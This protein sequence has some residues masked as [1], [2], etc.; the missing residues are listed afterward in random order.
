MVDGLSCNG[1]FGAGGQG[2][3]GATSAPGRS[4]RAGVAAVL[5]VVLALACLDL[6]AELVFRSAQPADGSQRW[7]ELKRYSD[8]APTA[9]PR[10]AADDA[11]ASTD[12]VQITVSGFITEEDVADAKV[13]ETLI[14]SGKQRIAGNVVAFSSSGGEFDAAIDLGRLLRKLGVSTIVGR[15]DQCLSSC[16]LAFMGGDRRV[17]AG[18]IGIHRPYFASTRYLLDRRVQYRQL[19]KKLKDYIEELDFPPSLYEAVMSVS[20]EAIRVLSPGEL[21]RFYLDGM[22]PSAEEEVDAETARHLGMPIAEYLQRKAQLQPCTGAQVSGCAKA[23]AGSGV[24]MDAAA[25]QEGS[26]SGTS[27]GAVGLAPARSPSGATQET[28]APDRP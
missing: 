20:A 12:E 14:K 13:M 17:A 3:T 7:S 2:A 15:G 22:S 6:R 5:G 10:A 18:R 19:Q 11:P 28:P 21:K 26:A 27:Q 23:A 8:L 16:V 25:P 24:S 9:Y 1:N 4:R